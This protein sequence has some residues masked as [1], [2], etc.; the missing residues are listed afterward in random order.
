MRVVAIS[1][2]HG[3]HAQTTNL[4]KG[5]VLVHSGDFMNSGS[6]P[7][8]VLSFNCWLGEQSSS[9]C[10]VTGGNLNRYFERWVSA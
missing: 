4:P 3:F 2:T 8:E 1:D 6:D 7:A 5:G 10:L 9:R